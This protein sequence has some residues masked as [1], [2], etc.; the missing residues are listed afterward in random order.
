MLEGAG[1]KSAQLCKF[2]EAAPYGWQDLREEELQKGPWNRR[3]EFPTQL[4]TQNGP[5]QCC[6]EPVDS[7][8]R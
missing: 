2:G 8:T 4:Q 1:G 5:S 3:L 6:E 7:G